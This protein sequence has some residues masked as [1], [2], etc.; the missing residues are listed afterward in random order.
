[1]KFYDRRSEIDILRRNWANTT[2]RSMMTVLTGRRRVGKTSLLT[3][4]DNNDQSLLYMYVSKDNERV[5]ARAT[6]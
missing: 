1:M 4:G 2:N 6:R 3:R 5:L